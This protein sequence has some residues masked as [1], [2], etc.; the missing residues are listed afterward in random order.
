MGVVYSGGHNQEFIINHRESCMLSS[1]CQPDCRSILRIPELREVDLKD[2]DHSRNNINRK[3][4]S[5]VWQKSWIWKFISYWHSNYISD[6]FPTCC[7]NSHET[8]I[9]V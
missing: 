7:T 1:G 2:R 4:Y 9:Y 5:T 8:S 6:D 3:C